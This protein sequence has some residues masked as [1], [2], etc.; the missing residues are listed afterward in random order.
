MTDILAIGAHPDDVELG[1]GGTLLRQKSKG[2]SIVILDLTEGELGTRGNAE[3]RKEEAARASEILQLDDRLNLGFRDG[4]FQAD[5]AHIAEVVKIIRR[6]KPRI[7][8]CNAVEDR[9]PDHGKAAELVRQAC[10]YSG[11]T[12]M[13]TTYNGQTQEVW[14]PKAVY[15]YIQFKYLRPDFLVDITDFYDAKMKSI[16]AHKSQFYDPN[17]DEPET[18][19]SSKGFLEFLDARMIEYGRILGTRYAEGFNIQRIPGVD[20][21]MDLQ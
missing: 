11:L 8:L 5:E 10:F 9:H 14:R 7:I 3:I 12:K 13:E 19:I 2:N 16:L 17:S 6:L 1:C 20:D 15:N 18:M 21:L 4:F